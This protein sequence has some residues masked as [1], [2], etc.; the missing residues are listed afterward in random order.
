MYEDEIIEYVMK[1]S[2]IIGGRKTKSRGESRDFFDAL[3]GSGVNIG[4]E[5]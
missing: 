2:N 5:M 4:Q 1:S 3:V